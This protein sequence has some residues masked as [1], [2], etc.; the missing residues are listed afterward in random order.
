MKVLYMHAKELEIE[1]GVGKKNRKALQEKLGRLL[2][3]LDRS[4]LMVR[5]ENALLA[6]V[7]VENGDEQLD[8]GRVR[9]DI[10]RAKRLIGVPS[11]VVGPFAHLSERPAL[12]EAAK[13]AMERLY[14][15]LGTEQFTEVPFG[16]DKSLRLHVPRHHYNVSL[17]SFAP[18]GSAWDDIAVAYDRYMETSGH[19]VAQARLFGMLVDKGHLAGDTLELGCGAGAALDILKAHAQFLF[20]LDSSE[21]MLELARGR[22]TGNKHDGMISLVKGKAEDAGILFR[23][24]TFH[25]VL[26]INLASY[27]DRERA[28]T[29]AGGLLMPGGRLVIIE[30][31]PFIPGFLARES[32]KLA[33]VKHPA[34]DELCALAEVL[35]F[36]SVER[37]S[38]EIDDVHGLVGMVFQRI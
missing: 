31:D 9:G 21:K 36:K 18:Q 15:A 26:M 7:C 35:G 33:G 6:L 8:L 1:S 17:K 32:E 20:G 22:L 23:L 37:M 34:V 11:V 19:Y 3:A 24:K 4:N 2:P 10:T 5:S 12:P 25:S 14:L 28:L 29:A 30:E 27:V 16:W 38:T 13:C